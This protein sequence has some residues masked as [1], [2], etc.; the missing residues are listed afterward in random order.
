MYP[1][2]GQ[3]LDLNLRTAPFARDSLGSLFAAETRLFFPGFFRHH[4]WHFYGGYQ[5]R[6]D[7]NVYFSSLVNYPRG[8]SGEFSDVLK[9]LAVN[10][11]FPLLYPDLSLSS[12]AYIKR[13]KANLFF[14]YAS[15]EYEGFVSDYKST[16]IELFADLH[17]FRF[18]MPVELGYRLIY[19]AGLVDLQHEFLFSI[20]FNAY[21]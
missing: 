7:N 16:G 21:Y 15:S 10:Y 1:R 8:Y 14:D 5:N 9:S 4:S 18:L 6:F 19:R 20:N 11:K 13:I 3:I 12:I 2:W 17:L